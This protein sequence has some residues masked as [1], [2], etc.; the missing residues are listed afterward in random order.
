MVKVSY[1]MGIT[2]ERNISSTYTDKSIFVLFTIL[3]VLIFKK[4][5]NTN[6]DQK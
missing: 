4:L 2:M 1:E 6:K 5:A 3:I